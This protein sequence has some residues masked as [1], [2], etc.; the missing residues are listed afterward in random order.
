[1]EN[2]SDPLH[3]EEMGTGSTLQGPDSTKIENG[4]SEKKTQAHVQ[5]RL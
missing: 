3:Q 4:E 5:E 2:L 1:M